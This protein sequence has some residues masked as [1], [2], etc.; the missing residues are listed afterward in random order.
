MEDLDQYVLQDIIS[1]MDKD[2]QMI[3]RRINSQFSKYIEPAFVHPLTS[4]KYLDLTN[5]NIYMLYELCGYSGSLRLLKKLKDI[6]IDF[7]MAYACQGGNIDMVNLMIARGACHWN[8]GLE[9]ACAGNN[10]DIADMMIQHGAYSFDSCLLFACSS[11]SR[12]LVDKMITLGATDFDGGLAYACLYGHRT[13]A[14]YMIS[15]GAVLMNWGLLMACRG[16]HIELVKL[17]ISYGANDFENA[18]NCT[19]YQTPISKEIVEYI[20]NHIQ[21][22]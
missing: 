17:M 20:N 9:R 4:E 13:L 3:I 12:Q 7:I 6:N 8:W 5:L 2:T 1:F 10:P 18:M 21:K 22:I 14:E 15:K 11:N 19:S 16:G